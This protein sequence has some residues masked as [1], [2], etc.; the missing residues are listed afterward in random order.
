MYEMASGV[1]PS[2]SICGCGRCVGERMGIEAGAHH[3]CICL[4]ALTAV[5]LS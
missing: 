2:S 1:T 4:F 3:R 5:L